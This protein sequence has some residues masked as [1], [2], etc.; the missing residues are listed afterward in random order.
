MEKKSFYNFT[1]KQLEE[2]CVNHN[3]KKFNAK[4]I[5]DWIYKKHATSFDEMHNIS[6]TTIQMLKNKL[7][8]DVFTIEKIQIDKND[9]TTKFLFKLKDGHYIESVLMYFDW[10]NSI[11]VSSEVGCSMGCQFCASGLLKLVRKLEPYEIVLQY[12]IINEYLWNE[13]KDRISN[14]DFM[15]VGE[16][17]DNYENLMIALKIINDPYGI[18]IGARH[19]TIST[20]GVVPKILQYAKDQPQMNL[21]IS[22]HAPIDS[23]RNKIMPINKAYPLKSLLSAVD[24][25]IALTNHKVMLSYIMLRDLNDT[26]ECLNELIKIA[27]NRLCFVNLIPYN[28]TSKNSFSTSNKINLFKNELSKNNI[29]VTVRL[30]RGKNIQAACGQLRAKY[31]KQI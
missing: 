6:K 8:L 21:A 3:A 25:Y 9:K 17:F 15:G 14:I 13:K 5:Y 20:C 18:G 26:D 27:K 30:G 29:V 4:Q 16:A 31:E 22:L 1:L 19:V 2:F 24:K 23:V 12:Y 7:S 10:G 11:C 28:I